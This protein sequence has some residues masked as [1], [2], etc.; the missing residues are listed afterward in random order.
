MKYIVVLIDGAADDRLEELGGKSPLEAAYMPTV[1]M[2]EKTAQ[3]GLVQTVP[4][5]MS[6]GSDIANLSVMGYDPRIYHTG[7]SPLEA[8][9][10]GVKMKAHDIAIRLN[11]VTLSDEAEF[12]DKRMLDYSGGEIPTEESAL[13]MDAL[14]DAWKDEKD[15]EIHKG[16]SYRHLFLWHEGSMDISLVPPHNITGERIMGHLPQ[17]VHSDFFI[18]FIRKGYEILKDHPVNQARIARGE[19]PANAPWLWGEGVRPSLVPFQGLYGL[20]AGVISAVDLIRG[21]ARGA[22]ME[23][24][25]VVGATGTIHTNFKGKG[26]AAVTGLNEGLDYIY[27]HL[28]ATDECGHQGDIDGKVRSLELIDQH[29]LKKLVEK[30]QGDYRLLLVPDHRTPLRT[31]KHDLVPVPYLLYDT[32]KTLGEGRGYNEEEAKGGTPLESGVALHRLLIEKAMP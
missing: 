16:V 20:K 27:I 8:L 22:D 26:E 5:G 31:R 28:E 14:I 23:V 32:R 19:R 9:S 29:I 2:L 18:R 1:R 15:F 17:G 24:L 3:I 12:L 11:L 6:P 30:V 13:L 7:R 25:P 10:I 21:I 4:E